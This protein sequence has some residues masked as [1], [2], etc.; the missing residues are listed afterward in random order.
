MQDTRCAKCEAHLFE[1]P[2]VPAGPCPVGG[3]VGRLMAAKL[4]E[5]IRLMTATV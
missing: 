4:D 5:A 3:G 2:G 1:P